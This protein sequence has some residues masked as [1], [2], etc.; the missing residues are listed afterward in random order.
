MKQ[1]ILL[2]DL[3]FE[4]FA[5]YSS[6]VLFSLFSLFWCGS[7]LFWVTGFL[8]DLYVGESDIRGPGRG[9][10]STSG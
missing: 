5:V 6:L 4:A 9:W 2:L 7:V 3:V 8:D 10:G 1:Q